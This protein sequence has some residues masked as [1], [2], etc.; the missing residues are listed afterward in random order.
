MG[1][2]ENKAT[3]K[4]LFDEVWNNNNLD[5]VDECF[6]DNFLRHNIGGGTIDLK[7]Y[8][9]FLV[10]IRNSF[11][12]IHRTLDDM[13]AEGD[14]IAFSFTWTG[15]D[16]RGFRGS[17]TGKR[18][19]VKECY[20]TRFEKGKIVEIKQY[21]DRLG[22]SQELGSIPTTEEIQAQKQKEEKE[23]ENKEIIRQMYDFINKGKWESYHELL[24]PDFVVHGSGSEMSFDQN[25]QLDAE[26]QT[27]FPDFRVTLQNMISEGDKVAFQLI[28]EMTH[29]GT[30]MG[31]APT[32]KQLKMTATYIV[33]IVDNKILDWYGNNDSLRL[34]QQLGLTSPE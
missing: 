21:A 2:E 33:R 10:Q 5:A 22:M 8:K 16:T 15:T 14:Q 29:M 13:V 27:A 6:A 20:I 4:R 32:G 9:Q 7:V 18:L 28:A 11:P 3:L 34:N 17:P 31:A 23:K 24:S 30:F 12:D 1:I 26:I 19:V 25:K